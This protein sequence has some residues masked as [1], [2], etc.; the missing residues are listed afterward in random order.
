MINNE[1]LTDIA[2]A[3]NNEAIS[4][5]AYT[6]FGETSVTITPTMTD[7]SGELL[8]RSNATR[9]RVV[10]VLSINSTKSGAS[11]LSPTGTHLNSTALFLAIT[12]G[13]PRA[14]VSLPN[15]LQTTNFDIETNWDI[16]ITRR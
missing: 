2:K 12:S 7:I 6:G 15:L 1:Y 10:N 13:T 5:V 9:S 16:T 11:I 8:P 4:P 3:L 14:M